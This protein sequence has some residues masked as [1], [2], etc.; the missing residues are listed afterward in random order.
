MGTW[1]MRTGAGCGRPWLSAST[2]DHD[3]S[4]NREPLEGVGPLQVVLSTR[5]AGTTH[6]QWK[7][8][9]RDQRQGTGLVGT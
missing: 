1:A 2:P 3:S 4:G 6:A 9:V 7:R 5:I 8:G